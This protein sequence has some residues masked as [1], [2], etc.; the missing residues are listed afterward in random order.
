MLSAIVLTANHY[1]F[2]A[3][4]GGVVALTGLAIAYN[5]RPHQTRTTSKHEQQVSLPHAA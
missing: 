5:F 1:I 2:D 4:A 3:F